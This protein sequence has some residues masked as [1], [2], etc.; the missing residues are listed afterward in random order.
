MNPNTFG[1][2]PYVGYSPLINPYHYSGLNTAQPYLNSIRSESYPYTVPAVMY[3]YTMPT[4]TY[5]YIVPT[6]MNPY[7]VQ[8][9]YDPTIGTY[10]DVRVI[11]GILAVAGAAGSV[12]GAVN[13]VASAL[14]TIN[15]ARS[16]ILTITNHTNTTLRKVREKLD[17]GG[18]AATPTAEIPPGQ[19]LVFG[20]TSSAWSIATGTEGSITYAGEGIEMTAYWNNPFIGSNSCNITVT[21]PNAINYIGTRECGAGNTNAQMRYE[22]KPLPFPVFGAIRDK[23]LQFQG[24]LGNPLDVEKPTF[25]GVG[26]SQQFQGGTVSWHPE[27][28]AFAVWGLINARWLQIGREKFG[29]PITDELK[30]PDGRG[31]FNHFRAIHLPGKPDA[32]IYW[33]PETGAHEIFGA[34]R[35]KWAELGWE[36]SHLG[37]PIGP[38]QDRPG[39]GR[40]QRFQRGSISWTPQGGAVVG[41]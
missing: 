32:S 7:F 17:H 27:L 38:E 1:H 36:K 33:S 34:I 15:A 37:Y 22:L 24:P 41:P 4:E 13:S 12:A 10:E 29:Y 19:T 16:V 26:R 30:T 6:E 2:Y 28:G 40:I 31:R 21:G 5:P 23:W 39:G 3:P 35:H 14:G 8:R 25:D 11:A 20:A 18:W 9:E